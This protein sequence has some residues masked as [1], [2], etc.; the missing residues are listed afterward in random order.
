PECCSRPTQAFSVISP[1]PLASR[2]KKRRHR[3]PS[4]PTDSKRG[5]SG[6]TRTGFCHRRLDFRRLSRCGQT[7]HDQCAE[8][9]GCA[10]HSYF[11][12]NRSLEWV[13]ISWI[14]TKQ[15]LSRA[16]TCRL[17]KCHP[18][19]PAHLT[20]RLGIRVEPTR[21]VHTVATIRP[22]LRADWRCRCRG[23]A[24]SDRGFDQTRSDEGQRDRTLHLW[25][26]AICANFG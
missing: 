17:R 21:A 22:A 3:P 9:A 13:E 26:A 15:R 18:A 10:E 1:I 4:R 24:T 14:F 20:G 19:L 7:G 25:R 12:R 6:R 8:N 16:E 23:R 5:L 2:G 11:L